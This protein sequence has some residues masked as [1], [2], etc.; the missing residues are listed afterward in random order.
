M[1]HLHVLALVRLINGTETSNGILEVLY[2]R[3]W[4]T[5]CSLSSRSYYYYYYHNDG[6]T[7]CKELGYDG[8]VV[9]SNSTQQ[10]TSE[11]IYRYQLWR[12]YDLICAGNEDSIY[13]CVD[14][15][16]EFSSSYCYYI[17]QYSC[18]SM[19]V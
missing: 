12:Y 1:Y 8:G 3:E 7:V 2:Q 10:L 19:F 6:H 17:A 14:H 18:Q 16:R 15:Y 9:V 4:Y 5:I 13:D 11:R